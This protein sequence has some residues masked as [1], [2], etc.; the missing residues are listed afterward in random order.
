MNELKFENFRIM[1]TLIPA[2]FCGPRMYSYCSTFSTKL[3]PDLLPEKSIQNHPF[4][5][6]FLTNKRSGRSNECWIQWTLSKYAKVFIRT[7]KGK[8][9]STEINLLS[10]K[11]FN[12]I[13][14]VAVTARL[15]ANR[16]AYV[17]AVQ[18]KMFGK[19]V[20]S[21]KSSP[22]SDYTD[23]TGF[24][25]TLPWSTSAQPT[26]VPISTPTPIQTNNEIRK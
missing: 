26:S 20:V 8:K 19:P 23:M 22:T 24:Y 7:W 1:F 16:F 21:T 13:I 3:N 9:G 11:Y 2:S 12:I 17:M 10:C 5:R 18:T 15:C 14:N 6:R 4:L 25:N